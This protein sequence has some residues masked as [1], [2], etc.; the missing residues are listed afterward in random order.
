MEAAE[1][2][3][4]EAIERESAAFRTT[5]SAM[6]ALQDLRQSHVT[7]RLVVEDAVTTLADCQREYE[8]TRGTEP[9]SST[10]PS[11][12]VN[13]IKAGEV[14]RG[15]LRNI[16]SNKQTRTRQLIEAAKTSS[17]GPPIPLGHGQVVRL[18]EGE[19]TSF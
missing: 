8:P 14:M 3:R 1:A 17:P 16:K 7:S 10:F 5:V 6:E 9:T 4:L 15:S 2:G 13:A 18:R 19:R 12:I 11:S